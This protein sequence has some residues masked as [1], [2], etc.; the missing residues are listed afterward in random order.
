[1]NLFYQIHCTGIDVVYRTVPVII[2][3]LYSCHDHTAPLF[4]CHSIRGVTESKLCDLSAPAGHAG[5]WAGFLILSHVTKI[6]NTCT[7]LKLYVCI[8]IMHMRYR[9]TSPT[10]SN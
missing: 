4:V 2:V 6:N 5:L 8:I 9:V 7:N 1:M 3:L 10:G